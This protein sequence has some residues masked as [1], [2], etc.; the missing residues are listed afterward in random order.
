MLEQFRPSINVIDTRDSVLPIVLHFLP[1]AFG[2]YGAC[3]YGYDWRERL[4]LICMLAMFFLLM[5]GLP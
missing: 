4:G 3:L 5:A 1:L 2:I